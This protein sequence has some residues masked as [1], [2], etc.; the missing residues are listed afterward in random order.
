MLDIKIKLIQPMQ[1]K[2]V[3]GIKIQNQCDT[4]FG[5]CCGMAFCYRYQVQSSLQQPFSQKH[6]GAAPSLLHCCQRAQSLD[7]LQGA[8]I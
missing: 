7:F 5:L 8:W 3:T 2:S 6:T 4:L 1:R